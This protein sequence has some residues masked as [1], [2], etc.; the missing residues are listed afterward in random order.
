MRYNGFSIDI[1]GDGLV[2]E[3]NN[4]WVI[5]I[6][7]LDT[8]EKLQLHPFRD[9]EAKQKII[10]WT[11]RYEN[12]HIC[13]HNGLGYDIFAL[14]FVLGIEF[15]V[16][17]DTFAG[18]KVQF[19]DTFYLSMFLNPDRERH[20]IEYF[21]EKFGKQKIDFRQRLIDIG[22]LD[23]NSPEG[24]EFLK[25]HPLMDEYCERDTL[26]GKMTFKSLIN[27]W[28]DSYG[29]FNAF[30]DFF[31]V[32]QKTFYLMSCQELT[33]WKFDI[34][35]ANELVTKIEGMMEE[36]RADVEPT[37][38][39]RKL[40][41]TE[42]KDYKMPAKPFK[43]DGTLASSMEKWIVKHNAQ[44]LEDNKVEAYGKIYNIEADKH[45]DIKLP[46]EMANQDQMKDWF[47]KGFVKKE[48]ED[49]Y[50]NIEWEDG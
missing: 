35:L 3:V 31:K 44:L 33:G 29:S 28:I 5:N 36:I 37:L 17:P 14:F 41:K 47:L 27:E 25:Y 11:S 4:L 45:L 12:P 18:Q 13:F 15:N 38:P 24:S 8:E 10:D 26:I 43:K 39:S 40:K 50:D 49:F 21:G 6:E 32:G 19:V 7:D 23:S 48:F 30:P 34:D 9:P 20:S 46:M 2:F 1:E 16:L 22:A 42:E